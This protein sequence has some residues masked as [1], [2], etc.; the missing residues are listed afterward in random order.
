MSPKLNHIVR[1]AKSVALRNSL[2]SRRR[3]QA[4]VKFTN[5][6]GFVYFGH[7]DQHDD[8]HHVIRG[9]TVSSSHQDEHYSVGSFEGYD[10]SL[11]DRYDIVSA[12]GQ[13]LKTHQ[14]LIIEID[15]H[16]GN[17][18]P[19]IFLGGHN[20]LDSSYAKLFTAVPSLQPVPLGTFGAHSQEFTNRYSLFA[21]AT[22]F[23]EVERLFTAEVT[24][25][26]AAHFW[27]LAVEVFEGA[28]YVYSDSKS[29]SV[30][31]LETMLKNGLWLATK[32]DEHSYSADWVQ[33]SM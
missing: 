11:V 17:N 23:I 32:L 4:I 10:V 12:P 21:T 6:F 8:E 1:I 13:K 33:Q 31:L 30:G 20:H 16:S 22:Q 7:V 19:H 28:L 15:L 5:R 29:L 25:T 2:L 18:T 27:P 26:I 9:L 14:W 3:K 24:R